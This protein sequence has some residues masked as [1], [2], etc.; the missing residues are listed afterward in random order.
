[1][2][3]LSWLLLLVGTG[4]VGAP[5]ARQ[6]DSPVDGAFTQAGLGG[7]A[8]GGGGSLP[9]ASASPLDRVI[10]QYR[11]GDADAAVAEF[12]S[13][14][15]ELLDSALASWEPMRA[16]AQ[17]GWT[18]TNARAV[19]TL[20]ML[21]TAAAVQR[22]AFVK[23]GRAVAP[24]AP[25]YYQEA[26]RLVKVLAKHARD[27]SPTGLPAV[28]RI[29]V[30]AFCRNWFMLA[31]ALW[32]SAWQ[33]ERAADTADSG[34]NSLGDDAQLFLAAGSV[35]E[36]RAVRER[37]AQPG[38]CFA[39]WP[40]TS[41]HGSFMTS[42]RTLEDAQVHLQRALALD[43][44]LAEARL[45]LGRVLYWAG[46]PNEAVRE[47]NRAIED[48]P[49]AE[50]AHIGYLGALFLGQL[51]EEVRREQEAIRA[52]ER[53]I[54]LNPRGYVAHLALGHLLVTTGRIVD[55]WENVQRTF[56]E[57]ATSVGAD[58]DPW[59]R[60]RDAQSWRAPQFMRELNTWVQQ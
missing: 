15:A 30:R 41:L 7:S 48:A 9:F 47:L 20:V 43:S 54:E 59:A 40:M 12:L 35:A 1:M 55:G 28:D 53:A 57:A 17:P 13:W 25:S 3:F 16:A 2:R 26:H 46:K 42:G 18:G 38:A 60:Y 33:C 19:A 8:W 56:G 4:S 10:A 34:L 51:H 27:G 52:Y 14:D 37:R 21:Q 32:M 58:L 50:R 24:G 36:T 45:H 23:G 5:S 22:N 6:L 49:A 44:S 29:G 31:T 39:P 11:H